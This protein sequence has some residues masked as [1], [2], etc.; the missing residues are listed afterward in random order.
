MPH[1]DPGFRLLNGERAVS[2]E[3]PRLGDLLQRPGKSH[4]SHS[5]LQLTK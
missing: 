3:A 4:D 1:P 2:A 5:M